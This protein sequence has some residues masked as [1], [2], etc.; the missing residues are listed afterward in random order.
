MKILFF[1]DM[2][3]ISKNLDKLRMLI[4]E[5]KFDKI[6]CLGDIYYAGPSYIKNQ[7][8]D[9]NKVLKFLMDYNDRLICLKGN[10][11]SDVDIRAS[12]FPICSNLALINVDGLDIYL[13]HGNEYNKNKNRKFYKK[14]ILVYGHEHFPYIEVIGDMTYIN[15]GSISLPRNGS[16]ETYAVYEDKKIT[17]FD[18]ENNIVDSVEF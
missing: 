17:I 1:S 5:K 2:H 7:D 18:I 13:T 12:D 4:E 15:V 11:D 6:V 16:N 10:C 8:Y 9:S 14:G 3:G